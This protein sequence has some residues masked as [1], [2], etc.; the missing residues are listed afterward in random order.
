MRILKLRMNIGVR[1]TNF[2]EGGGGGAEVFPPNIFPGV[3][4]LKTR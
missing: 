4:A 3:P 2:V 1:G